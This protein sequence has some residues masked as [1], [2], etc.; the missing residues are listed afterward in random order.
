MAVVVCMHVVISCL[1]CSHKC[2]LLVLQNF[3]SGPKGQSSDAY[4]G[5][6]ITQGIS[7]H[8]S[9][10]SSINVTS[11]T[12]GNPNTPIS[13]TGSGLLMVPPSGGGGQIM[14]PS[15][16]GGGQISALSLGGG[17]QISVPP[18]GQTS[19]GSGLGTASGTDIVA[20]TSQQAG[21]TVVSIA[22]ADELRKAA[23]MR[24]QPDYMGED[25]FENRIKSKLDAMIQEQPPPA[26]PTA[27]KPPAG[28]KGKQTEEV[29]EVHIMF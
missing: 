25:K 11:T 20:K 21:L 15:S 24:G 17:G 7:P 22:S 5:T 13:A 23:W 8:S 18:S 19:S 6:Q 12:S 26:Q 10:V 28:Q 29:Q 2:V 9:L 16:G 27:K 4:T 14:A 3:L 1:I